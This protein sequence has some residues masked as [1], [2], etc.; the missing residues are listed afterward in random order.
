MVGF[1]PSA[2]NL[3]ILDNFH[4]FFFHLGIPVLGSEKKK[5]KEVNTMPLKALHFT[6]LVWVE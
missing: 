2:K 5:K 4:Y 6:V 1:S 3:P